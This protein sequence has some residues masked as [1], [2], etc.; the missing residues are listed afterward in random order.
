MSLSVPPSFIPP[1]ETPVCPPLLLVGPLYRNQHLP[2]LPL[3]LPHHACHHHEHYR[4][5]QRH[6]PHR[7]AAGA[8]S[9]QARPGGP[10]EIKEEFRRGWN[11]GAPWDAAVEPLYSANIVEVAV[12]QMVG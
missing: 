2:L 1:Q 9:A 8:S 7:E 11:G 12:V 6:P 4:H 5:V 10:R 3:L